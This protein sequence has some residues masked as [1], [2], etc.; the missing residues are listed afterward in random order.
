MTNNSFV[1]DWARVL[2]YAIMGP[3]LMEGDVYE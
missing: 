3:L 2:S 1:L